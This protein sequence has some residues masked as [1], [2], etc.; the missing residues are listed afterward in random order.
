MT[1]EP[2]CEGCRE[3]SREKG[4]RQD[5]VPSLSTVTT[6][7]SHRRQS[8]GGWGLLSLK[9]DQA[10]RVACS[11]MSSRPWPHPTPL[12]YAHPEWPPGLAA[13]PHLLRWVKGGQ[14]ST[15]VL[16]KFM[17]KDRNQHLSPSGCSGVCCQ[18]LQTSPALQLH[19]ER[20]SNCSLES[21]EL[22]PLIGFSPFLIQMSAVPGCSEPPLKFLCGAIPWSLFFPCSGDR[23][24]STMG[25]VCFPP[26]KEKR[27]LTKPQHIFTYWPPWLPVGQ[28]LLLSP[29][30][31][32]RC[33]ERCSDLDCWDR[34]CW[35]SGLNSCLWL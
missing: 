17:Q 25:S 6:A 33:F 19:R 30:E 1:G 23:T 21:P 26:L 3:F 4:S 7:Q 32:N 13:P 24:F 34:K 9:T 15:A 10:P 18:P 20:K 12:T 8:F 28:V 5:N 11:P 27:E 29:Q 35:S 16:L 31:R 14:S 2:G 22:F